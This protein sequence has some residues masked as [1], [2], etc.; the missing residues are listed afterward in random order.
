MS[1]IVEN[2]LAIFYYLTHVRW[3]FTRTSLADDKNK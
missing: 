2:L 1:Q 3:I